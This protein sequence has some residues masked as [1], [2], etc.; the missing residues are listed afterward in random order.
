M[1]QETL[2]NALADEVK[3]AIESVGVSNYS[4][5]QMQSTHQLLAARGV[6]LVNQVRYLL[7]RQIET[8]ASSKPP[9]S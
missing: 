8:T 2:M 4:A 5:Q 3:R 9:A 7:A 1:S 6:P